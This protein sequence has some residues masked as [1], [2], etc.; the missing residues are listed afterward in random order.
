M[1]KQRRAIGANG[2]VGTAHIDEDMGM[3]EGRLFSHAHE[4]AGADLD[5]WNAGCVVE[6]GNN[7]LCHTDITAPYG[8][9]LLSRRTIAIGGADS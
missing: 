9:T 4:F 1:A 5:H 3:I 8:A 2:F 6:M 7:M